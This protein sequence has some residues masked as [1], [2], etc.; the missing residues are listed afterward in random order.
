VISGA[1]ISGTVKSTSGKAV[2]GRTEISL[3]T[4]MTSGI[5]MRAGQVAG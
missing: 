4:P 1:V 5:W 2:H 3:A